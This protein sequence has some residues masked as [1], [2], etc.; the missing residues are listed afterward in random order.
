MLSLCM[1][2]LSTTLI[3]NFSYDI[4]TQMCAYTPPD[5]Q[6][7]LPPLLPSS[8]LRHAHPAGTYSSSAYLRLC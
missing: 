7:L 4:C 8:V 3:Q 6:P 1:P 2:V 5:L